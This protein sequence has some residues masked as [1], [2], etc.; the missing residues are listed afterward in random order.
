MTATGKIDIRLAKADDAATVHTLIRTMS[1]AIPSHFSMRSTAEDFA[2]ALS[3]KPP[4]IH[5][6]IAT[7]DARPVGV[8]VFF[9]TFS[10]WYG[11]RG[12]YVQDIFVDENARGQNIGRRLLAAAS[13]WGEQHHADHLRLSVDR[14][15][16]AAQEFYTA[17]KLRHC[18]D[19]E[20]YMIEGDEFRRLASEQ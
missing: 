7:Q 10:T 8:L 4:D 17:N 20:I 18:D 12:I 1:A 9:T 13:K 6:F 14:S 2:A 19:E 15:N 11:S 3:G 5:A 16:T